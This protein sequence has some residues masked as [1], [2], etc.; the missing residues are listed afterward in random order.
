MTIALDLSKKFELNLQ[1]AGIVN[2][3]TMVT[4][5]AVDK[6]GSMSEE[7]ANG[8]VQRTIDLFIAAAMKFDDNGELDIGFFDTSMR[9]TENAV[10][11]DV[12]SYLKTKGRH[13]NANNGT[14]Y[15]PIIEAFEQNAETEKPG[16]FGRLF[17]GKKEAS[18]PQMR[19]YAGVITDGDAGDN[20]KFE[21]VMSQTNG[22]TF[23]QFIAIGNQVNLRYLQGIADKYSHVAFAHIPNPHSMT[24]DSFY[25]LI[26]N[27]KLKAWIG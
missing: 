8:W 2:I 5:L 9:L 25:E 14:S 10:A 20:S 26:C 13:I 24:D 6:S 12:G 1:K 11:E 23:Y 7:F 15:A 27:E 3:P 19:Q 21:S 22:N 17:G 4:K 16:F 18:E